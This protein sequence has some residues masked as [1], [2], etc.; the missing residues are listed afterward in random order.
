M[1]AVELIGDIDDQHRLRAQVPDEFPAGPV[2]L[3]VLLPE[4]DEG[5]S[6]WAHGVAKEWAGDLQD[7]RQDL[8]TMDDGQPVNAAG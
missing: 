5:G 3:I 4:E 8:Y 2:R 1:K 6:A 7:S